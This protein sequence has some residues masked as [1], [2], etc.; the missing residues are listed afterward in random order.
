L[1]YTLN[2]SFM[3]IWAYQTSISPKFKSFWGNPIFCK[4][5]RT[6]IAF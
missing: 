3:I 5:I 4:K 2:A 6:A 1:H